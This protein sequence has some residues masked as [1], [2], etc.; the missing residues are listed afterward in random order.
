MVYTDACMAC[1]A[2][3]TARWLTYPP[4]VWRGIFFSHF[5]SLFEC[6]L[7]LLFSS[8]LT[9][10]LLFFF[11]LSKRD[12]EPGVDVYLYHFEHTPDF[13]RAAK[14]WGAY[15][16]AELAFVFYDKSLLS[17][18]EWDLAK[19][20][21]NWYE[22]SRNENLTRRQWEDWRVLMKYLSK[23]PKGGS[24]LLRMEIRITTGHRLCG[25]NMTFTPTKMLGLICNQRLRPI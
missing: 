1:P 8:H 3:R 9:H 18:R 22:N 20:M 21:V 19:Q 15:H 2:R 12:V 17:P 24:H 11:S 7:L 6:S 16:G 14:C 13:T 23:N 4:R 25:P 10:P 5:F